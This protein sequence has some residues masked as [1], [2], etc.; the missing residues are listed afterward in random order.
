MLVG[1]LA[2]QISINFVRLFRVARR[3]LQEW[4]GQLLCVGIVATILSVYSMAFLSVENKA[5]FPGKS[6]LGERIHF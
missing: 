3:V 6:I 5:N 1:S 4:P 2:Y